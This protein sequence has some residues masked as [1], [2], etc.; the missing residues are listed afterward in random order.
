MNV[1][2][3]TYDSTSIESRIDQGWGGRSVETPNTHMYIYIYM[4]SLMAPNVLTGEPPPVA[5]NNWY[6]VILLFSHL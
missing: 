2:R 6:N 5:G 3:K 4:Y 1:H